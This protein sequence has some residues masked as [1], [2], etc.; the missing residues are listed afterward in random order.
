MRVRVWTVQAEHRRVDERGNG[1]ILEE[2]V[3]RAPDH[4]ALSAAAHTL[5]AEAVECVDLLVLMIATEQVDL[6]GVADLEREEQHE[7][8]ER[9]CAA[10]DVVSEE[11]V[12]D[13][14][15]GGVAAGGSVR[16]SR[17]GCVE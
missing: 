5:V 2:G 4:G 13:V 11:D 10:V 8:L 17:G 14:R 6:R 9:V 15:Q 16:G 3:D 12:R 1:Q 7:H